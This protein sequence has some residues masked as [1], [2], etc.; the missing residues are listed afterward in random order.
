MILPKFVIATATFTL[1]LVFLMFT[2]DILHIHHSLSF[3]IRTAKA[4][5]K[6]YS[7][8]FQVTFFLV[9]STIVLTWA[10]VPLVWG[11]VNIS[12]MISP[13]PSNYNRDTYYFY[14]GCTYSYGCLYPDEYWVFSWLPR[15]AYD[16]DYQS[17]H[18]FRDDGESHTTL[19]SI[20][21]Q[22]NQTC[23]LS[24]HNSPV[25]FNDLLDS[26]CFALCLAR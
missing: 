22:N 26:I 7:T 5:A 2:L 13:G 18:H 15:W 9:L 4:A 17:N 11:L 21:W 25:F 6:C 10:I 20:L 19:A 14:Y 3:A 12:D 16:Y 1:N 24:N 23:L 8:I